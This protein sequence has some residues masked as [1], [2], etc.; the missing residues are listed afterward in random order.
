MP[1]RQEWNW[2][3]LMLVQALL[4]AISANIKVVALRFTQ[5]NWVIEVVLF[6]ESASD[7]DEM[8]DVADEMSI[9]IEDIKAE[10]SDLA[11]KPITCK[12]AV[13]TDEI[14]GESSPAHR[15]VFKRKEH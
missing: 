9:F 5:E 3:V 4:G 12:I 7:V 11:Y 6:E 2:F 14:S 1:T 8:N 13:S 15:I 10:I